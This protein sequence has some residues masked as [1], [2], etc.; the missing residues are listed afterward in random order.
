MG[1]SER[2]F[3][4]K[5]GNIKSK[6][7]KKIAEVIDCFSKMQKLKAES[8]IKT[9]EMMASAMH[10]LEKLEQDFAKSKDL[11]PESRQRLDGEITASR[12]QMRQKYDELK[13]RISAA[14]VPQ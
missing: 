5:L 3:S 10:D 11:A 12:S 8:L 7:S 14:I 1:D 13:T 4:E 6:S 2:E 9:E